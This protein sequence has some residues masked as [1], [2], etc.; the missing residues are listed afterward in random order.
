MMNRPLLPILLLATLA[1]IPVAAH[2]RRKPPKA[3]PHP[4]VLLDHANRYSLAAAVTRDDGRKVLPIRLVIK[5]AGPNTWVAENCNPVSPVVGG[6]VLPQKQCF[7]NFYSELLTE[8]G[9]GR[10]LLFEW[11][12]DGAGIQLKPGASYQLEVAAATTCTRSS[13]PGLFALGDCK[14]VLPLRSPPFTITE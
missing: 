5:A 11:P 9:K 1:A 13:G 7:M 2:R 12:V 6:A 4:I 14:R 3:P 8:K 10:T